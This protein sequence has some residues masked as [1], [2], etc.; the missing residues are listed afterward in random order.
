MQGLPSGPRT[1]PGGSG[2]AVGVGRGDFPVAVLVL[3]LVLV[4]LPCIVTHTPHAPRGLQ[5]GKPVNRRGEVWEQVGRV[6]SGPAIPRLRRVRPVVF[7]RLSASACAVPESFRSRCG[8]KALKPEEWKLL[9]GIGWEE[10]I[11]VCHGGAMIIS[12]IQRAK[13]LVIC[14]ICTSIKKYHEQPILNPRALLSE[15]TF[16]ARGERGVRLTVCNQPCIN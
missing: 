8:A 6:T 2:R 11:L 15:I 7:R 12:R 1:V 16:G 5:E 3:V 10:K 14:P 13:D 9:V 4:V